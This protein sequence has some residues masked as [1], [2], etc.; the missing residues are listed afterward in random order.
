MPIPEEESDGKGGMRV[1]P[2]GIEVHVDGKRAG[3][4]D[5]DGGEERPTLVDVLARE[6]EGEEQAEKTV[7]GGGEGH[8]DAIG[9]GETVGGD[10]G[11]Q[12]TGEKN[13]GMGKE[14][15]RTP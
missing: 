2:G 9:S 6:T 14:K 12:S 11:T 1:G 3:P 7:D 4:P 5:G 10:G 13:A 8:G 15:E